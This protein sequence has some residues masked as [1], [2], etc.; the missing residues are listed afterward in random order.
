MTP[1]GRSEAVKKTDRIK[2]LPRIEW[3]VRG[4]ADEVFGTL[5]YLDCG[6]ELTRD[7]SPG[8]VRPRPS[9]KREAQSAADTKIL[10]LELRVGDRLADE[11]G[12]FEVIGQPY[13]TAGG[14]IAHAR[15][16]RIN[17][18]ASW[19]IRNWDVVK[20]ISVR[21]ASAEEDKR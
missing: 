7:I 9:K 4:Q 10:P 16:Q 21:R 18:P 20:R 11:T 6:T 3:G 1:R 17:E 15:V 19:E 5:G 2:L 12:E 14:R 8:T 13:T